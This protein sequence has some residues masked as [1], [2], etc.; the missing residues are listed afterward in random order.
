M[1][2][3]TST[4]FL[5]KFFLNSIFHTKKLSFIFY[6]LEKQK[7]EQKNFPR[8]NKPQMKL[9]KQPLKKEFSHTVYCCQIFLKRDS[10]ALF[11][12]EI[13]FFCHASSKDERMNGKMSGMKLKIQFEDCGSGFSGTCEFNVKGGTW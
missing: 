4:P 10:K 12:N 7:R 8:L 13:M 2:I 5:L 11:S 6:L 3:E 1:S 9:V